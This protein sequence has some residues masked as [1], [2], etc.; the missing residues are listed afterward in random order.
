MEVPLGKNVA[1]ISV[2]LLIVVKKK[3]KCLLPILSM[4]PMQTTVAGTP[5][6]PMSAKFR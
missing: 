4:S 5:V 6:M 2:A 1:T 3:W